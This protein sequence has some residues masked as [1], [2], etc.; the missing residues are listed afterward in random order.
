VSTSALCCLCGRRRLRVLLMLL[1]LLLLLLLP[2][3]VLLALPLRLL[4]AL[5]LRRLTPEG[6]A[7]AAAG[8]MAGRRHTRRGVSG[9]VMWH[10]CSAAAAA[11]GPAVVL[12]TG[13]DARVR[14]CTLAYHRTDDVSALLSVKGTT[15]CLR[16]KVAS[17]AMLRTPDTPRPQ[18]SA[19]PFHHCLCTRPVTGLPE[20]TAASDALPYQ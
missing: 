15:S 14:M 20:G 12:C 18:Q 19:R 2:V 5:L 8:A 3:P 1:L 6:A 16:L 9:G 4:L 7:A 13:F 11:A 17:Y 10:A